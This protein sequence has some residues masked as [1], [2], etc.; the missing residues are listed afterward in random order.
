MNE[1]T[2]K[3][4]KEA[5]EAEKIE[6]DDDYQR[7]MWKLK[8]DQTKQEDEILYNKYAN[9]EE[10]KKKKDEKRKLELDIANETVI[11]YQFMVESKVITDRKFNRVTKL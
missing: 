11:K 9:K 4:A 1:Q 2:K 7:K 6:D 3:A 10:E 5:E 8:F